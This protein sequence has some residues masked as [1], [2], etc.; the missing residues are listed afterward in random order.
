MTA[1]RWHERSSV[2]TKNDEI[3][4][5]AAVIKDTFARLVSSFDQ[6]RRLTAEASHELRTPLPV[7]D[8]FSKSNCAIGYMRRKGSG[9]QWAGW[10]NAARNTREDHDGAPSGVAWRNSSRGVHA[11]CPVT[12]LRRSKHTI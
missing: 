8:A 5:L 6:P 12:T 1:D 11:G 9:I 2:R 3:G 10:I 7:L 4:R